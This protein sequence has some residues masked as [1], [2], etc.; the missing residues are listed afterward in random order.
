MPSTLNPY[1]S[2]KDNTRDAMAFYQSVLG[3]ELTV[4]TFA[5]LHAA[6]DPSEADLVMH[7]VL[8]T[9]GGFTLMASD[10]PARM[11]YTPGTN[12]SLSLSGDA[13]S[14]DELRRYWDGLSEGATITMPL[15]KA[16]WGDTFGMLTDRFGIGWLV[17]IA[18]DDAPT[19]HS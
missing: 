4:S 8:T 1:I 12:F 3:G 15:Q 2:F 13:E 11:E 9:P 18:G 7:S 17:N 6:M 10:T 19:G 14:E 16:V 5:D